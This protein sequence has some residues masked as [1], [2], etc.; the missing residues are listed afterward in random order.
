M[1]ITELVVK[2]LVLMLEHGNVDVRTESGC[3]CCIWSRGV[4]PEFKLKDP[5]GSEGEGIYL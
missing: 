2:L 1:K 3:G 5:W 4:D